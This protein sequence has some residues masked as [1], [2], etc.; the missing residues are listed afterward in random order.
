MKKMMS[1]AGHGLLLVMLLSAT[2][3]LAADTTSPEDTLRALVQAN[4]DK[5]IS[6]LTR[7][8]AHD[9]DI[10]S[11]TIGGRKYVGWPQFEREMLE[12]FRTVTRLEIPII[13]V[14]VWTRG[15]VAWFAME[16]DYIR[17]IGAGS[18]RRRMLLPLR[19]TGVLERRDG[20]WIL[21]TWHESFRVE[22]APLAVPDPVPCTAGK[23]TGTA[24]PAVRIPDLSGEWE[25]QEEDKSYKAT[26]D[27]RG[28]GLYS[29]QS[30]RIMT[31]VVAGQK[32]QGTWQQA[33]NDREGGFELVLS[34]DGS[35]AR[36][37]WWYT[38]VGEKS[39]IPPRQWG[40]SYVWKRT[41]AGPTS[42]NGR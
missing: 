32:W 13:A 3:G 12:E 26:L 30:G 40:G 22:A 35:Q 14:K 24:G 27:R 20:K 41:S 39:S 8:M 21:T 28:N 31:T 29:W 10:V 18:E 34:E 5:D 36:G 4:A 38:R 16:L 23:Q 1:G 37:V 42:G 9:A 19:E 15:E 17:Y 2:P 7:L 33:G 11:Y 6:T 25:V